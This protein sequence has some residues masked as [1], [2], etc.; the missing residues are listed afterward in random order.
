MASE[1]NQL[2]TEIA[3]RGEWRGADAN[4]S[5]ARADLDPGLVKLSPQRRRRPAWAFAFGA[6]ALA[7]VLIGGVA[8]LWSVA[9]GG[10]DVADEVPAPTLAPE[11]ATSAPPATDPVPAPAT[12]APEPTEAPPPTDPPL[13]PQAMEWSRIS[14]GVDGA[15]YSVIRGGPGYIAGGEA[16][17]DGA[18]WTS[19]DGISWERVPHDEIVFGAG[20]ISGLAAGDDGYVAVGGDGGGAIWFSADGLSWQ[21][22]ADSPSFASATL[23]FDSVAFGPAG[24]V[25]TGMDF[26]TTGSAGAEFTGAVWVSPD[27]L[28]WE[29]VTTDALLESRLHDVVAAAPGYV[30]VGFYWTGNDLD[31]GIWV[32]ED[33]RTWSH[34]PDEPF[35]TSWGEIQGLDAADGRIVATGYLESDTD[36]CPNDDYR[37]G[38]WVSDG[39]SWLRLGREG[40]Q[41]CGGPGSAVAMSGDEIVL[42]GAR[43]RWGASGPFVAGAWVS[44]DAGVTWHRTDMSEDVFGRTSGNTGLWDVVGSGDGYVAAGTYGNEA[45]IWVGTRN[46]AFGP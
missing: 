4:M 12:E 46:D 18:L 37:L 6:A 15:V 16:G 32:S 24:Y 34:H 45:T 14:L 38:V 29:R 33:G 36:P 27:G 1:L 19:T 41:L 9:D 2:L 17:G 8:L 30:A 13:P 43:G 40:E 7:L 10:T 3:E 26:D 28:M 21:R 11:P 35:Y 20:G 5:A 22:V 44:R 23:S 31:V 42:V 25:A 39:T